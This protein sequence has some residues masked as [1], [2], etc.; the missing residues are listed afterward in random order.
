MLRDRQEDFVQSAISQGVNTFLGLCP[1]LMIVPLTGGLASRWIDPQKWWIFGPLGDMYNL[2]SFAALLLAIALLLMRSSRIIAT[3]L[4]GV[5]AVSHFPSNLVR[6]APPATTNDIKV[7]TFNLP[8]GNESPE[9]LARAENLFV[10]QNADIVSMQ[11][12]QFSALVTTPDIMHGPL[13]VNHLLQKGGYSSV[14]AKR[15]DKSGEWFSLHLPVVAREQP[16][17]HREILDPDLPPGSASI[18]EVSVSERMITVINLHLATHG[19][20]KPWAKQNFRS[21]SLQ[22]WSD[23][24]KQWKAAYQLR[25]RQANILARLIAETDTPLIVT[26]DLNSTPRSWVYHKIKG[27]MQDVFG[28]LGSGWGATYHSALPIVRIDYVFVSHHFRP[29][30]ASVVKSDREISDHLPVAAQ[31]QWRE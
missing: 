12:T 16:T 4:I 29:I 5:L 20:N 2:V 25:A 1:Y 30:G 19:G 24:F 26:G 14:L 23:V 3:L 31:F 15:L 7:L 22:M 18:Y 8:R 9:V 10:H 13:K 17:A 28:A 27:P 21:Y 6:T 11:E